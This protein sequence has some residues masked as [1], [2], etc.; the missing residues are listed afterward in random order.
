MGFDALLDLLTDLDVPDGTEGV[1][2]VL[3]HEVRDAS[4][5]IVEGANR[6]IE[7]ARQK[8]WLADIQPAPLHS[9]GCS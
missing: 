1:V 8:P 6:D 7:H 3:R 9:C 2:M 5:T 4:A